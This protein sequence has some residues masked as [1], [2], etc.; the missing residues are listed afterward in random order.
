MGIWL[1]TFIHFFN[2]TYKKRISK[3]RTILLLF[4]SIM[5]QMIKH[6]SSCLK[7]QYLILYCKEYVLL[8]L[9]FL[10]N[11]FWIQKIFVFKL[12]ACIET[13]AISF[14]CQLLKSVWTICIF[15]FYSFGFVAWK[16][17]MYSF[18]SSFEIPLKALASEKFYILVLSKTL[19]SAW[20]CL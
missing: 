5:L 7:K 15:L 4:K 11:I 12:E 10:L 18:L 8:K 2:C 20:T 14:F 16:D 1:L 6:D 9:K 19:V 17:I 13:S 3:H